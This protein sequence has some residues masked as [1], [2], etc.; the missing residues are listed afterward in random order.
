MRLS[1]VLPGGFLDADLRVKCGSLQETISEG[2]SQSLGYV[3]PARIRV[4]EELW[5]LSSALVRGFG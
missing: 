1:K 5:T 3:G 4:E 2:P